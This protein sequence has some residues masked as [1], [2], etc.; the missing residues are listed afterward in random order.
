[1]WRLFHI[2]HRRAIFFTLEQSIY[3]SYY[4]CQEEKFPKNNADIPVCP[5]HHIYRFH[6]PYRLPKGTGRRLNE[7][8]PVVVYFLSGCDK[9]SSTSVSTAQDRGPF[10]FFK[11]FWRTHSHVLFWG[12]WYPCFGFLVTSPLG[13]KARVGCLIRIAEANVMYVPWDQP[14]VLHIADLLTVSIAGCWPGSYLAQ[15]YYCVAAVSLEP[16][17]NRSWVLCT[18]HSATRPGQYI[19]KFRSKCTKT[20]IEVHFGFRTFWTKFYN[21]LTYRMNLKFETIVK[22][23]WKI[24]QL[25]AVIIL[26]STNEYYRKMISKIGRKMDLYLAMRSKSKSS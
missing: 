19:V 26:K 3:H 7:A 5:Y 2:F 15:G 20:K 13:F 6:L 24:I 23:F 8:I 22:I 21:I 16:A 4:S 18:N 14:L 9:F 11:Y 25:S 12:H 17:I 1:M 10:F